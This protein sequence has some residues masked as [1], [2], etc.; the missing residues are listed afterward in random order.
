MFDPISIEAIFIVF[1]YYCK[2]DFRIMANLGLVS[3]IFLFLAIL[4]FALF[5][6]SYVTRSMIVYQLFEADGQ[7]YKSLYTNQ[8]MIA[9]LPTIMPAIILHLVSYGMFLIS[10]LIFILTSKIKIKYEG[11]LFAIILIIIVT[12]PFE[13][14]LDTIDLKIVPMIMSDPIDVSPVLG[15]IKERMN[16]LSSFSLIE[17]FSFAA[18][19]FL[20][21]FK[22][23]RKKYEN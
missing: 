16:V 21:L 19:I 13:I 3:K 22:P 15:L 9:V 17:I 2:K 20:F 6:G 10:S 5:L 18:V 7:S 1:F 8:N 14:Y 23:L 12:A 4:F 11:W